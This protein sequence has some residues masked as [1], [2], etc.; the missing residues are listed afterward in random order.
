MVTADGDHRLDRVRR[1]EGPGDG[2]R[3]AQPDDGERFGQPLAQQGGRARMGAVKLTGQRL[4]VG[5][6]DQG[7]G[8]VVGTAHALGDGGG[9]RVG[10]P[11]GDVR[12]LWSWQRWM[13]GWSNTSPTARRSELAPSITTRMGP[14]DLQAAVPQPGQ[15]IGHH[16]G[17]LGRPLGQ[18]ERDLGAV[19]GDPQRDH[20]AVLGDPDPVDHQRDQAGLNHKLRW[21]GVLD[22][23]SQLASALGGIS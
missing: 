23:Q 8:V 6:G 22:F 10:E 19:R 2:G 20:T 1:P 12:S 15:Q 18:P 16:R 3:H 14:G 17:V 9:H 21:V 13:T 7:I 5:F 4:Q 11:V